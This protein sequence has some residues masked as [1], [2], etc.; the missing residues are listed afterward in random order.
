[1]DKNYVYYEDC[2]KCEKE[3]GMRFE[4]VIVNEGYEWED[5]IDCGYCESC[6]HSK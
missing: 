1:M 2:P 3:N 6:G 4:R 5:H